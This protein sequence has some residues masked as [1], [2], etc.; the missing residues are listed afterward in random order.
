MTD[1]PA[2][3]KV[4][5]PDGSTWYEA[6]DGSR[7]KTRPGA[8]KKSKKLEE[9]EDYPPEGSNEATEVE[10]DAHARK[11]PGIDSPPEPEWASFDWVSDDGPVE[12]VPGM[13]KKVR[14]SRS[15]KGAPTKKQL[16][17]EKQMNMAILKVGYRTADY[18]LTRWKRGVLQDSEAAAIR[19]SE[20]D[21]DWIADVTEEAL[22]D[23]GLNIGAAVGPGMF[24]LGA[25]AVWFG[26]PIMQVRSEAKKLGLVGKATIGLGKIMER[27]PFIG[28]S[29]K[30]RRVRK[31]QEAT[32]RAFQV[33]EGLNEGPN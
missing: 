32:V 10:G 14:P 25:N 5:D 9:S 24:A 17:A 15:G 4:T 26:S 19:H 30:Q 21:Y 22:A 29:I 28:K 33:K 16:E 23:Q 2:S 1:K 18:G 8:Y 11:S 12:F 3:K 20:D 13:L 27:I 31:E 6:T 7:Y